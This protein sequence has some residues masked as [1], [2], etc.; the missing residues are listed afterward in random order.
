MIDKNSKN[1]PVYVEECKKM[2]DDYDKKFDELFERQ[3]IENRARGRD[4]GETSMLVTQRAEELKAIQRKY[5]Y[6][7]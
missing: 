7:E 2:A 1:Y 3:R 4:D 6:R 5:G